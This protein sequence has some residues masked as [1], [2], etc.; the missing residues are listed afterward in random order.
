MLKQ[1]LI[2]TAVICC[3]VL[4]AIPA[5]AGEMSG[6][7]QNMFMPKVMS[8]MELADGTV[9]NRML[10]KGFMTDRT[11]GSPLAVASMQCAGTTIVGK[12]GAPISSGGTCDSV[13]ADGD[14]AL[15]W[16]RAE[17]T[18][19]KWGFMGGTGKWKGV[20]GGG[21]YEQTHMWLDGKMG[22]TWK[23]TWTMK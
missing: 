15:Y 14:I 22:N 11:E 17:G 13:D 5:G 23:G 20:E 10:F 4:T 7:G 1:S 12:E 21:T 19:G 3:L 2:L 9:A 16:W 18:S 8:S 6:G